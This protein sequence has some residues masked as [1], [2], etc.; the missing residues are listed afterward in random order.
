VRRSRP[1]L[2]LAAAV[3]ALAVALAAWLADVASRVE[4]STVDARFEVRGTQRPPDDVVVVEIDDVTFGVLRRQW[5][6]P[7]SLHA[8]VI[9]RLRVARARVIAYDVQFTEPTTARE[10]NALFD[11]VQQAGNVVLATTEVDAHGRTNVLGGDGA[12]RAA[13]ARAGNATALTDPGGVI[14]RFPYS[15]QKLDSFAVV[16]A[17]RALGR[18][19]PEAPFARSGAWI[20]FPGPPGTIPF[21]SFSRV[22]LGDVPAS[23]FRDKIVVVGASAPAL[24]DV[25]ATSASGRGFMSGAEVH[26]AAVSTIL[27]GFP[28]REPGR[29]LELIAIAVLVSAAPLATLRL[30]PLRAV[31]LAGGL[32]IGYVV[33]AQVAFHQGL[34]LPV[35]YPLAGLVLSMMAA[36]AVDYLSEALERER[37]RLAFARFVPAV[38]V[39]RVVARAGEALRLGGVQVETTVLFSDLRGFTTYSESRPP[40]EVIGVLNQY[41]SAMT[42]VIMRHGGT[43]ISYL[44]DG[45]LALFGA[46]LEQQDHADRAVAAAREMFARLRLFNVWMREEGLGEGFRMG[47]GINTG[48]LMVGNVGSVQH[49]QY[50]AIGDTVNTASRLEALTKGTPYGL[51]IAESTYDRLLFR[52]DDLVYVDELAVRGRSGKIHVWSLAR[53]QGDAHTGGPPG[54]TAESPVS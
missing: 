40:D 21:V 8:R 39:D 49:M 48:E 3:A 38:V 22:M 46:P 10:D 33:A 53:P 31:I 34:I 16:V 45:I 11:A 41:L 50:T 6:F 1:R 52:P 54:E 25:H 30:P 32:G 20:D 2:H 29:W 24:Q 27:R 17:E 37:V 35:V 28:L 19:V 15:V 5:P 12:L 18:P 9:D 36:L 44:G 14:R 26:A 13:G 43:L 51:F 7:R 47:V 23:V 42:E 4:L